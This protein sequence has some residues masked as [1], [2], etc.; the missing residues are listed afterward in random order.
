MIHA[1]SVLAVALPV[2]V[3]KCRTCGGQLRGRILTTET[4]IICD[5]CEYFT[6]APSTHR[7]LITDLIGEQLRKLSCLS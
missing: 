7:Q 5:R 1:L 6:A 2:N 4:V 3:V